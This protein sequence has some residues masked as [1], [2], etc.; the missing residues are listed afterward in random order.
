MHD[1]VFVAT[2]FSVYRYG[3]DHT[4][5]G[6]RSQNLVESPTELID[7]AY[8]RRTTLPLAYPRLARAGAI[9]K[10]PAASAGDPKRARTAHLGIVRVLLWLGQ[11]NEAQEEYAALLARRFS[12]GT[13]PTTFIER[14]LYVTERLHANPWNANTTVG[15]GLERI[16]TGFASLRTVCSFDVREPASRCLHVE[17]SAEETDFAQASSSGYRR[18]SA[19][20]P[21]ARRL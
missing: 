8:V 18:T 17:A 4:C 19:G 9:R 11:R 5:C 6:S 15:I 13:H 2:L 16:A 10:H 12:D 20:L 21:V 1:W 3:F 14:C 7:T